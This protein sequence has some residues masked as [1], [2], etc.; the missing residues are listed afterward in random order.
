MVVGG[1][2][3]NMKTETLFEVPRTAPSARVELTMFKRKHGIQTHHAKHLSR[4]DDPWLAII[5]FDD[6]KGKSIGA[7]MADSCQLYEE[8]GYCATG[9]GE[10]SAIRKLCAQRGIACNI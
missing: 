3:N 8:S 7:I 4:E 2:I 6:D 5:P 10:L 9:T 1:G